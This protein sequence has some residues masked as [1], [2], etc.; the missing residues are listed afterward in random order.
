[1][2]LYGFGKN[3]ANDLL[4][5]SQQRRGNTGDSTD[6]NYNRPQN[7]DVVV[8]RVFLCK[9]MTPISKATESEEATAIPGEYNMPA[10][11]ATI[12][13][14][15]YAAPR[16]TSAAGY[17]SLA[18]FNPDPLDPA[19][20]TPQSRVG[21]LN[22]LS[23]GNAGGA[24]YPLDTQSD[25]VVVVYNGLE[26]NINADEMV[27]VADID[28]VLTII[29]VVGEGQQTPL[30]NFQVQ[31]QEYSTTGK[32][33]KL[34]A[35]IFEIIGTSPT[36]P[37]TGNPYIP[38]ETDIPIFDP[39]VK[40]PDANKECLGIAYWTTTQATSGGPDYTT[41]GAGPSYDAQYAAGRWE[42]LWVNEPVNRVKVRLLECMK[43]TEPDTEV[44]AEIYDP[45]NGEWNY[46][47]NGN[48]GMRL[49]E[50][51]G[52]DPTY[53]DDN[54]QLNVKNPFKFYAGYGSIAMAERVYSMKRWHSFDKDGSPSINQK[55]AVTQVADMDR[56]ARWCTV[57]TGSGGT[58]IQE[59][60]TF[61]DGLD[62][63][64][65]GLC[66]V[67]ISCPPTLDCA[68]LPEND[69]VTALLDRK[70]GDYYVVT[71]KIMGKYETYNL[72]YD[73]Q[74]D[75]LNPCKINYKTMPIYNYCDPGISYTDQSLT[76]DCGTTE[77]CWDTP[78]YVWSITALTDVE[79][80]TNVDG[81]PCLSFATKTFD[82]CI[83]DGSSPTDGTVDLCGTE[84]DEPECVT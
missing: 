3:T 47:G 70:S 6:N 44:Q 76:L 17:N 31:S 26:V 84:C 23:S 63:R 19:T 74:V 30:V 49:T 46:S 39:F 62:P 77:D 55:W 81:D 42:V 10:A 32:G 41:G 58:I 50:D 28:G 14:T 18:M 33:S 24:S 75:T 83:P 5:L 72:A 79:I 37:I 68:C 38:G 4:D 16:P 78:G 35:T 15:L 21:S 34:I 2:P 64:T 82:I 65:D 73:F 8:S 13:T 69:V 66:E 52:D 1:M 43:G 48:T 22:N 9:M 29:S 45:G 25:G 60:A 12:M 20:W 27:T 80:I 53:R 57:Q 40:F 11:K 7:T 36:N 67:G 51:L 56:W 71:G 54:I 61:Y 59:S